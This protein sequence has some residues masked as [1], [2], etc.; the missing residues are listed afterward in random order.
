METWDVL[1]VGAG[2][3]GLMCAIGAANR[4]RRV[5]LLDHAPRLGN[6]IRASGGG[7]CNFTNLDASP[8]HYVS[9]N[10]HF[11]RS[12]LDRFGPEDFVALLRKNTILFHD[13]KPGQLFCDGPAQQIVDM[14]LADAREAGAEWREGVTV[15]GASHQG[16][17]FRV[18]TS[19]EPVEGKKLVVACGGLSHPRLGATGL[20]YDLARSFGHEIVPTRPALD[21]FL[22]A[23]ESK[24]LF[25]DLA[26][27]AQ[28]AEVTCAGRTFADPVLF[29]HVGLS[30]PAV[31]QASLFWELGAE[32]TV[33]FAPAVPG[34]ILDY[35]VKT[36]ARGSL[37]TPATLLGRV[38]P[39]RLAECFAS[40]FL[41][42]Q[43]NLAQTR[44]D[45][46]EVLA[47]AIGAYRFIPKDTAGWDKAEVT[48]GGVDTGE[49][50]SKTMESLKVPGL[51][52]TGE[53]L[54]VTGELGGYNLQWAWSSGWAAGEA[55]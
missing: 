22:F 24:E 10:P 41:P 17:L 51:Y 25:G 4:G 48:R 28:D 7:R 9:A 29:T 19:T 2:A 1:I 42:G 21:G 26:G 13:K 12:A 44:R 38:L 53:V 50:S 35:L 34:G 18:E 37:Q 55:V 36:K 30:G 16:E 5:L 46:L 49:I 15:T 8:E 6:K 47:Q 27:L 33:N 3:S 40:A 11:C 52:F 54:D 45:E 14:L 32:V 43:V 20:G 23:A 39:K 31:L